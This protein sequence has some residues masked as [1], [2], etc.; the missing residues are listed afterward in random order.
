MHAMIVDLEP[1]PRYQL[2]FNPVYVDSDS[3]SSA[4]LTTGVI[5]PAQRL[6]ATVSYS[7]IDPSAASDHLDSYG[8]A[9]RWKA[10]AR[11]GA[12][13]TLVAGYSDTKSAS[14]KTQG[15]LVAEFLVVGPL[16]VATDLRWAQKSSSSSEV[17]DVIPMVTAGLNLGKV[18]VGGSYT[19][20]NDVDAD[21]DFG[22]QVELPFAIGAF[23]GAVGKHGTWRLGFGRKFDFK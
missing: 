4:T 3:A 1:G 5:L 7:Y 15:G 19:F 13:L 16:T 2:L 22:L 17:D 21:N 14:R 6:R 23:S 10:W 8:G 12:G 18:I 11:E 20:R 9:V